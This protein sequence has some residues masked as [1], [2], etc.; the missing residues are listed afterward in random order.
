M[1]KQQFKK[2]QKLKNKKRYKKKIQKTKKRGPNSMDIRDEDSFSPRNSDS[3]S[4]SDVDV[5]TLTREIVEGW[6]GGE[7]RINRGD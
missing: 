5:D 6:A 2:P 7:G 1:I 3:D 4:D